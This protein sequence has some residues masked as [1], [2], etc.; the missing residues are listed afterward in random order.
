MIRRKPF[1]CN[2]EIK[3]DYLSKTGII[4]FPDR[5]DDTIKDDEE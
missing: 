3:R 1:L 5:D 4:W 2:T